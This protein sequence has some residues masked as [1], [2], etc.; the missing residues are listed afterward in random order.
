MGIEL[1]NG[2]KVSSASTSG[3]SAR[4]LSTGLLIVDES[5]LA[6]SLLTVRDKETKEVKKITIKELFLEL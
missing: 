3:D 4:G 2:C 1:A 6:T 5:I